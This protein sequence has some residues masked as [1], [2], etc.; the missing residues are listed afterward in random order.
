VA[1]P[2]LSPDS[3]KDMTRRRL[4]RR[5]LLLITGCIG[6][7]FLVLILG[8]VALLHNARFHRYLLRKTDQMA[9]QRLGTR[10]T[11][12]NFSIHLSSL[13][14]DL[15]GLTVDGAAPYSDPP[16]LQVQHI[17]LDFRVV[18]VSH[19]KWH[20]DSIRVDNL[21]ARI[22]TDAHGISNFPTIKSSGSTHTD[23]FDLGVRHAS[24]HGGELYANDKKISL[25]A[26]LHD[27]NFSSSFNFVS[28][29]YYGS[30]SY[31]DGHLLFGSF[32]PIPHNLK[33]QFR[34]TPNVFY[35]M[36]AR[37]GSGSS[38]LK[39]TAM[40][41]NY[42]DPIIHAH[43]EVVLD[44]AMV[45]RILKGPAIPSGVMVSSGSVQYQRVSQLPWLDS[46][47][48][49]GAL[50]S[51]HLD[52]RE[53]QIR[54]QVRNVAAHY[55]LQNGNLSI[56]RAHANLLG[57][58]A[59][60]DLIIHD[61][62]GHSHSV[63]RLSLRGISMADARRLTPQNAA[64]E[65]VSLG[66]FVN[67]TAD[68]RWGK[69]LD[70]LVAQTTLSIRGNISS[71]HTEQHA[72]NILP[73]TGEIHGSY[74]VANN[75]IG[76]ANSYLQMPQTSLAMNGV[77]S[78]RSSL[79]VH[80]KSTNLAELESLADAFRP[81]FNDNSRQLGLAG[82]ISFDGTI[83]GSTSAPHIA[84]QLSASNLQI[85]ETRW[86]LLRTDVEASPWLVSL[87][88]GTLDPEPQGS[89]HFSVSAGLTHWSFTKESLVQL[90]LDAT[91]L[92]IEDVTKLVSSSLP[93]YG[94][95]AANL[96]LHGT[97]SNPV[98]HGNLAL[99]HAMI[100]QQP[101]HSATLTFTGSD[102]QVQG[103]LSAHLASGTVQTA[104]SVRPKQKTYTA[105]LS[106]NGILLTQLEILKANNV[107]AKG[108]VNLTA[109][110]EGM[111]NNPK[112]NATLQTS[113]LEINDQPIDGLTLQASLANHMATANLNSQA[114]HSTIRAQAKINLTGNYFTE[115]TLDTQS[116]PLQPLL[117]TYAPA[118]AANLGGT[119][120]IHATLQGPLKDWK[121]LQIHATLPQLKVNYGNS[122]QLA[123]A[124]PIH[125]DYAHGLITLQRAAIRGTDTDLQIQGSIPTVGDRPIELLLLG[126]M[127]LQIAQLLDP[128]IKSSGRLRFNINSYGA[129]TDP[130]IEGE[131]DIV[132][133]SFFSG[134]LP[135]GIQHGNGVL[136]LTKNR[137]NIKAFRANSG[138]GT[139]TAQ[140]GATFRPSLQFDVGATAKDIRMLY[141]Q[142][143]REEL[144]GDI[145]LVGNPDN[146]L[147][148]GRVQIENL[149]FTPDF[150]LTNFADQLTGGVA[151]PPTQ[152]FAQNTRLNVAISSINNL[153]L[154][155]RTLS[156]DGTANL[157]VRGTVA[158]PVILGRVNFDNGDLIFNGNRFTVSGGT[159]QF[160]NPSETQPVVN[161]ALNTT[162]QQYNIHL[163]FNGP[164]DQLRTNYTS[165]PSL[166]AADIINLLAFGQTT[167]ASAANPATPTNQAAMGLVASQ[168]SSQITSR[169]AK[170][171]GI[172][173][174]SINPVLAGGSIQGPSGAV[175]TIQQRVTGNLFVT[176]S[177]NVATTQNQVIMGQ[178]NLS[179][180]TSLSV[181]RDQN[182][183]VAFDT[184]FKRNW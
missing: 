86:R 155:S 42:S 170:I 149:S 99:T 41:S 130:N 65:N 162:I 60:G 133:A 69:S 138:G 122:V 31:R 103:N 158:Q 1:A 113:K 13:S 104:L 64:M 32:S 75:Q 61:I 54:T 8:V 120:E 107:D 165:D 43:Y 51:G 87:Q 59:D 12:Q 82:T 17:G 178:Y 94:I 3:G 160:V 23:I 148:G 9:S 128:D 38:Q 37:V 57:G 62:S 132:E 70:D 21:V 45:R 139:V 154:V 72:P 124:A 183:G 117:S 96:H 46:L 88:H 174:L 123:A 125:I 29:E 63:L 91:Q 140:G 40:L 119:T 36:D 95:L 67:A 85:Q 136:T 48:V 169:V 181:T 144:G 78:N 163:R 184:L 77:V 121:Q 118:Q 151:P 76:L 156:V 141:P 176:F 2:S 92:N 14:L 137:L 110:G 71:A 49:D 177:T 5:A 74:S 101:I 33:A 152:G 173:Q 142:G 11:L 56:Q 168:V 30:L 166:P 83:S 134:D 127:D 24:L 135:L 80:F 112:L 6:F 146:A 114:I 73:I 19:K 175:V 55:F 111:L 153:N 47:T 131:V 108:T 7:V 52:V 105:K 126:T 172:S 28:R 4:W 22:F 164:V 167:E 25:G 115:A 102:G 10:V 68:A 98:G 50:T 90:E 157:Q 27:L 20:F 58:T 84:G 35:L 93:L 26:D 145:R 116:I 109:S 15:Y 171:A 159:V 97:E 81:S 129:R 147:L 150:D 18:S 39:A 106:A 53:K 100:Y 44:G 79:Q 161:L 180:R 89:V 34:A 179:P 182:G 66:G 16:L 143:V